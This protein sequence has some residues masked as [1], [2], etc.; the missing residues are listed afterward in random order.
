MRLFQNVNVV[1]AYVELGAVVEDS[2]ILALLPSF[3]KFHRGQPRFSIQDTTNQWNSTKDSNNDFFKRNLNTSQINY[4]LLLLRLFVFFL[5]SGRVRPSTLSL[6]LSLR[7]SL[8]RAIIVL[9]PWDTM[10][11]LLLCFGLFRY[12]FFLFSFHIICSSHTILPWQINLI[13][14]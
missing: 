4:F 8:Y 13:S 14:F 3:Y 12:F 6:R 9:H 5:L 11:P 1:C 2:S 10:L 7:L